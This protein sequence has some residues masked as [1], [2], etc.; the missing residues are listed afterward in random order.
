MWRIWLAFNNAGK[1]QMGFKSAFKGLIQ[2]RW[3][4]TP[5]TSYVSNSIPQGVDSVEHKRE[6]FASDEL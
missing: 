1:W 5:E 6:Y 3:S 2:F 4:V